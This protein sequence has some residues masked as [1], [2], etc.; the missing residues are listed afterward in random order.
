L[1]TSGVAPVL[2][3]RKRSSMTWDHKLTRRRV[4]PVPDRPETEGAA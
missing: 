2:W 4:N 3:F 1:P